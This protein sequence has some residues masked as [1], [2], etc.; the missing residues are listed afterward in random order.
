M[1]WTIFEFDATILVIW[2]AILVT[3]IL[4]VILRRLAH[5]TRTVEALGS[6]LASQRP[7]S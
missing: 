1:F 7:P 3:I 2:W 4:I 6:G 5:L